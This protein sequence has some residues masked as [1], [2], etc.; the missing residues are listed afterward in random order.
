VATKTRNAPSQLPSWWS[1]FRTGWVL[2]LSHLQVQLAY[3]DELFSGWAQVFVEI[4]IFRQL[5]TA[6]Y[7]GHETIAG[8]SLPQA[9]TY[10]VINSIIARLLTTWII[11][12]VNNKVRSG[13]IVIDISRPVGFGSL[14]CSQ[15][16][17]EGI[18]VFLT[19]SLPVAVIAHLI[20]GLV[21]PASVLVWCAFLVSL[22]AGFLITFL[23][24][25]MIG[26][27]AF[28]FTEVS[29]FY[30]SKG[31]IIAVLGGTYLP[32]WLYP[33]SLARILDW[34]PFKGISYTPLAILVGKIELSQV[35]AACGIQI[36]W[37][38]VLLW[39]SRRIYNAVVKKLV[40]QGG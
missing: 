37:L 29:G 18:A 34:L 4:V 19:V 33:P 28:W 6:L 27:S 38:I 5:W 23:I 12:D 11:E 1:S 10:A 7:R 14:M 2:I 22:V 20:W 17:G 26:L 32:L 40:V 16:V 31:S 8:V 9:M 21:L 15:A 25:Y 35:P 13:D 36:I 24:D 3:R 30:W 39:L